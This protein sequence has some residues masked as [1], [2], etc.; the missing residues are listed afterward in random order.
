MDRL[1]DEEDV[2][3]IDASSP[4]MAMVR[5][6]C[7]F[8]TANRFTADQEKIPTLGNFEKTSKK[9]LRINS[10]NFLIK[11]PAGCYSRW[12]SWK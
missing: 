6:S 3:F 8:P 9:N 4:S 5:T 1:L 2:P 11:K 12:F 10:K 7:I